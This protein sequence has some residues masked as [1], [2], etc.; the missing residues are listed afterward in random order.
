MAYDYPRMLYH[1]NQLS[2]RTVLGIA[3][4]RLRRQPT[5]KRTRRI[6]AHS[7][8]SYWGGATDN[9]LYWYRGSVVY[10]QPG[11]GDNGHDIITV[12][13]DEVRPD[14]FQ[15]SIGNSCGKTASTWFPA[16]SVA[17]RQ[18][19]SGRHLLARCLFHRWLPGALFY[20]WHLCLLFR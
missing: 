2:D 5:T 4:H 3:L 8:Y 10:V 17:W 14:G 18:V 1:C 15:R 16:K 20:S 19:F 7:S 9:G 12:G 6:V 13:S 11:P